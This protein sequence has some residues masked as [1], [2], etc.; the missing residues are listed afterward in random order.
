MNVLY[1]CIV[2][3]EEQHSLRG[4]PYALRI[5]WLLIYFLVDVL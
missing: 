3:I 1:V 2:K 5:R 4:T